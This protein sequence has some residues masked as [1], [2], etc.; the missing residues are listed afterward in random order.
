[1][2]QDFQFQAQEYKRSRA[3]AEWKNGKCLSAIFIMMPMIP[4][5]EEDHHCQNDETWKEKGH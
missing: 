4:K 1:M 2:Y 5:Q 3:L